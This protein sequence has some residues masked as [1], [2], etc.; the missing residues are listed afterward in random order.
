MVQKTPSLLTCG[1][2][3]RRYLGIR[4]LAE[5]GTYLALSLFRQTRR[6]R[7]EVHA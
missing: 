2:T 5:R 3:L 4:K 7:R 1:L 6:L